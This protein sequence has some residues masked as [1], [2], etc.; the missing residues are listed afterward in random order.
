MVLLA[1]APW[2]VWD[3]DTTLGLPVPAAD[4]LAQSFREGLPPGLMPRFRLIDAGTFAA[5]FASDRAHMRLQG[6]AY[7]KPPP[8][9]PP[10]GPPGEAPNLM[11]FVE[12]D[13]PFVGE[14]VGLPALRARVAAG[15]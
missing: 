3:L 10:I 12:M 15:P 2:E 14:V 5:S 7:R 9:W 6:G 11:R 4:Y 1:R 8:P 13:Q